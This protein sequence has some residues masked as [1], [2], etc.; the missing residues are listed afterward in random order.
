[1]A[2]LE[3]MHYHAEQKKIFAGFHDSRSFPCSWTNRHAFTSWVG[4][5]SLRSFQPN[6]NQLGAGSR[7]ARKLC[8]GNIFSQSK[9]QGRFHVSPR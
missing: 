2:C 4:C 5:P 3:C 9:S 7:S 1:M 6:A 8:T